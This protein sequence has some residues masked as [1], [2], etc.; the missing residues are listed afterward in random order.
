MSLIPIFIASLLGSIHCV[1]MCGGFVALC[2]GTTSPTNTSKQ[3]CF[4]THGAYNFGRFTSYI[5]L[6]GL[7]GTIGQFGNKVSAGF[8]ISHGATVILGSLVIL[9]GASSLVLQTKYISR[10]LQPL[11]RI[12]GQTYQSIMEFLPKDPAQ[13]AFSIGLF[14]AFLPCGWLYAYVTLAASTG[15]PMQ[16]ML[17]MATFWLGTV[18]ALLGIGLITSKLSDNLRRRMPII[19]ALLLI[20]AGIF[21]INEHLGLLSSICGCH[22]GN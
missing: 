9:W 8:G 18:P 22:E 3:S 14:S 1:G 16:G 6:G 11:T 13:R 12:L 19:T 20:T 4:H 21:A 5:F 10:Y 2:T 15:S 17:L 7:A